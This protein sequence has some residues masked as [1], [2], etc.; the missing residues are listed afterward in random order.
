MSFRLM[1]RLYFVV[2]VLLLGVHTSPLIQAEGPTITPSWDDRFSRPPRFSGRI[3][4]IVEIGADAYVGGSFVGEDE[5]DVRYIARWD[6]RSWQNVGAG[7]NGNVYALATDGTDLYVGGDF[8]LAGTSALDSIARWDGT[9]WQPVGSGEGLNSGLNR[10]NSLVFDDGKLYV[11]GSFTSIDNVPA[12]NVAVWDGDSWASLGAGTNE[13]VQTLF[14]HQG[15]LYVG[16]EFTQAG[17][18]SAKGIAI[19]NGSNWE[20]LGSGLDMSFEDAITYAITAYNDNIYVGGSFDEAG[21]KAAKGLAVWTGSTWQAV[22]SGA[23]NTNGSTGIVYTLRVIDGHLYVGGDFELM[24]STIVNHIARWDGTSWQAVNNDGAGDWVE[25]ITPAASGGFYAGGVFLRMDDRYAYKIAQ[26]DGNQWHAFGLGVADDKGSITFPGDVNALATL[27][28][29]LY[30]GGLF[31]HVGGIPAVNLAKWDGNSWHAI[32]DVDGDIWTMAT[33]GSDLYIGGEFTTV[34]N[35]AASN[36]ARYDT[37]TDQWFPLNSGINGEAVYSLAAGHGGIYAGGFFSAAG[38]L[39]ASNL[40][41]W[42]GSSW[43][44]LGSQDVNFTPHLFPKRTVRALEVHGDHVYIGGKIA[45]V[46]YNAVLYTPVNSLMRW[47]RGQDEW[48][49]F[50]EQGITDSSFVSNAAGDVRTIAV[51]GDYLYVGGTFDKAGPT[52]AANIA[53]WHLSQQQWSS[54]GNGLSE[55]TV[56]AILGVGADVFVTGRFDN[57]GSSIVN[58]IARWDTNTDSWA[59]LDDGLGRG[60]AQIGVYGGGEALALVDDS[61]YVGGATFDTTGDKLASSI[62][63]W[64]PITA[65]NAPPSALDQSINGSIGGPISITL[66]AIGDNTSLTYTIID[67]PDHGILTG[68]PPDLIYTPDSNYTGPD[69]FTFQ[70]SDGETES[71]GIIYLNILPPFDHFVY[72]PFLTK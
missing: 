37:L 32:G 5:I 44:L 25:V 15:Q 55:G 24:D 8:S 14:V 68:T 70:V 2:V 9:Q 72:I 23:L 69:T 40:A 1:R 62:G 29:D 61:L 57:A 17:G 66:T 41:F 64:H 65:A 19:W 56:R 6:G 49:L 39:E 34:A 60:N 4:D 71:T 58:D 30:I 67:N 36:I 42:N 63:R 3:Y 50:G 10:I 28:T 18:Q 22:G 7:T 53:R 11:G 12:N 52:A 16:G 26:Y 38:N 33:L 47:H 20:N 35:I 43:E 59:G 27:G 48:F 13:E 51:H 45:N 54:L 21:G 31:N 46:R